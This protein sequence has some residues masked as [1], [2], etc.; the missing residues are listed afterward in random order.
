VN[1]SDTIDQADVSQRLVPEQSPINGLGAVLRRSILA[2]AQGGSV[3]DQL[4]CADLA[5]ALGYGDAARMLFEGVFVQRGFS[6]KQVAEQARIAARTGLWHEGFNVG[7]PLAAES[8]AEFAID[9]ALVEL[10]NLIETVPTALP[11]SLP[12]A[13]EV[14]I[15][16]TSRSA[17]PRKSVYKN[18]GRCF[19]GLLGW[20][21]TALRESNIA[22]ITL[23]LEELRGE[24]LGKPRWHARDHAD[25]PIDELAAGLVTSQLHAFL[26]RNRNLCW[27]PLGSA[28]LFAAASRLPAGGL[29]PYLSNVRQLLRSTSDLLGLALLAGAD[30]G[31]G[32]GVEFQRWLVRLGAHLGSG[33]RTELVDYFADHGLAVALAGFF[34]A[35]PQV[36][37]RGSR[38]PW[39]VRDAALDLGL[40]KLAAAAQAR[41][42]ILMPDHAEEQIVLAEVLGGIDSEAAREALLEALRLEPKHEGALERLAV[43]DAGDFGAFEVLSGLASPPWRVTLRAHHRRGS[44]QKGGTERA[45]RSNPDNAQG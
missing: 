40:A 29:G 20:L 6:A 25:A 24:I 15:S 9:L 7:S 36:A 44:E 13:V 23:V 19:A 1:R 16:P 37:D 34:G 17:E 10:R 43:L 14:P 26:D 4:E 30:D 3:E 35:T 8:E 31:S 12:L 21:C 18:D 45:T 5:F 38:L 32:H 27:A 33:E 2:C 41:I 39:I 28:T 42:A 11:T 22:Q